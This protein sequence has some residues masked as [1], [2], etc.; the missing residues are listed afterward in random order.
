MLDT[1]QALPAGAR[2]RSVEKWAQD[3]YGSASAQMLHFARLLRE[4]YDSPSTYRFFADRRWD[5]MPAIVLAKQRYNVSFTCTVK[6]SSRYQIISHWTTRAGNNPAV[7]V[8]SK[9]ETV[10][11]NIE[12]RPRELKE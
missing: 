10:E 1:G 9:G 4:R 12:V 3:N 11:V 8:K 5:S 2:V 6:A 7:V